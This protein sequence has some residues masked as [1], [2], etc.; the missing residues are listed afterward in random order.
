MLEFTKTKKDDVLAY[1]PF[2]AEQRTHVSDFSLCFQFMWH[3]YFAP[4]YAIVEDC[5]V[6]K[7][8]YAGKYYFHYPLSR[9]GD[10]GAQLRAVAALE[11][12]CRD[13]EIR[14]HFTN[15]PREF[16][17]ELVLRYGQDV[18]VTN[19]RRWR[20]YLYTAES[21]RTYAGGKYSGQRNHVNKFKKNYPD[22]QFRVYDAADEGALL[23][24]LHEYDAAQRAKGSYLASEE[25]DEV[26]ELVPVIGRFGL[27]CGYLTAGGKIVACSIGER[28]GDMIVVHVE[29]A[30]RAYEGA[31]PMIAQQFALAFAGEGV[32]YL[33]RMDDAGD[34][35]LRKSKLQYLPCE[36]V[37][38]YNVS[39]RRAID[40]VA[41]LPTIRTGRLT[42]RPVAD[43]DAAVYARLAGDVCR[44]RW[45]GYDWRED[46]PKDA[47]GAP[48]PEEGWFLAFARSLFKEKMEMPL[49]IYAENGLVGEVVLHRFGYRAE[50]EIGV[51]LLPEYEGNGYA[52]EAVAAYAEHA[53][54]KL[55][56]ERVEAKHYKENARSGNML[57]RAGMRRSGEDETYIY[58]YKT[59][60]M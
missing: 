36:I 17:P 39:P 42:L 16:V 47:G 23:S 45:W 24:F 13:A 8:L 21:F 35:G 11:E 44:N 32:E 33:N 53:F 4:D 10:A 51:R 49:G 3:K 58:Y 60:A 12:Y 29:K 31:Y 38:K 20:D 54:I 1:A 19:I 7:E 43:E 25:M 50:A 56:L 28:C 37:G 15:V 27:L 57:L 22:W 59:P 5:L 46:A 52:A 2:F 26:Y 41:H 9:T 48:A 14:L 18:S 55:E 34:G 30:L 40:G 6:L